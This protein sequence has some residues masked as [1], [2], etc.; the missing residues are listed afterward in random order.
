MVHR[1]SSISSLGSRLS[2]TLATPDPHPIER[3]AINGQA[4][5]SSLL[6]SQ[7]NTLRKAVAEYIRRYKRNPPPNFDKWFKIARREE[8]VL[9]D[10]FDNIM[11]TIEPFWGIPPSELRQRVNAAFKDPRLIRF[12]I[13]DANVSFDHEGW[14]TWIPSQMLSWLPL[15]Y[16]LLL[17]NMTFAVNILDEPRVVTSHEVISRALHS[18]SIGVLSASDADIPHEQRLS[19]TEVDFSNIGRHDVWQA[20]SMACDFKPPARD[21]NASGTS[22][23]F[24][25]NVTDGLDIC[26][27]P[28]LHDMHGFLSSPDSLDITHTLVPIFSQGKPSIFND[29]L[30]PSPYYAGR[31]D[32]EDYLQEEDPHWTKKSDTLYWSGGTTGGYATIE[33]WKS[34]HRQRLMLSLQSQESK[35][36]TVL[37]ETSPG[38]WDP[39]IIPISELRS[40]FDTKMTGIVQ[41]EPEACE[42]ERT[43]FNIIPYDGDK[44]PNTEP[45]NATYQSKYVLDIDGNGFSGRYY[46][47]LKSRSAVVKQTIFKEWH[48][49]HLV[50]WVHY[51]PLSMDADELPEIMRFLVHDPRGRKLGE[52][53]ARESRSWA[54]IT[55]RKIDLQLA[56]LRLLLEYGRLM[57]DDRDTLGY[58]P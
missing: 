39:R 47:L 10:E 50:P 29:I 53:I 30:F 20:L 1:H 12:N 15:D 43:A 56:F 51:I 33:N 7:S 46:R 6:T 18:A 4:Q 26:E 36:V 38:Q 16:R 42:A 55:F 49:G 58:K 5:F 2:Q 27:H 34:L 52:R 32:K 17:P 31:M 3:L 45:L 13:S 44:N 11:E 9:L 14:A 22:L 41:C 24:I 8:Y 28:S 40:L 23:R 21:D 54:N 37:N 48:D 57:S 25:A 35:L 19:R